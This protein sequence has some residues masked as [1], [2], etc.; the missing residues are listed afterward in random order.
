MAEGRIVKTGDMG[1][2]D[3]LET[4]GYALLKSI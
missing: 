1:L 2:V 3:Q 4:E